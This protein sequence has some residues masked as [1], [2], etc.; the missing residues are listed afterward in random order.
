MW[1]SQDITV[2]MFD[3]EC[4]HSTAEIERFVYEQGVI[5]I[6]HYP[7]VHQNEVDVPTLTSKVSCTLNEL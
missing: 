7:Y 4:L 5:A 3:F 1:L 2:T 6:R